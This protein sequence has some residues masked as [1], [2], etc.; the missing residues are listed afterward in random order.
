MALL[1]KKCDNTNDIVDEI[2]TIYENVATTITLS[3]GFRDLE[4]AILI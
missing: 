3:I 4:L 1:F 2:Y